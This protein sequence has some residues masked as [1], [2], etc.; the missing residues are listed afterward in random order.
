VC[1]PWEAGLAVLRSTTPLA[2]ARTLHDGGLTVIDPRRPAVRTREVAGQRAV[3]LTKPVSERVL[4][5]TGPLPQH[6]TPADTSAPGV[7][8]AQPPVP[9]PAPETLAPPSDA[10]ASSPGPR[11]SRTPTTSS[12]AGSPRADTA[13]AS[14]DTKPDAVPADARGN[15]PVALYA[16]LREAVADGVIEARYTGDM[17]TAERIL[18]P[19]AAVDAMAAKTGLRP[20]IYRRRITLHA[21]VLAEGADLVLCPRLEGSAA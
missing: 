18:I 13:E 14:V 9:G 7:T 21:A 5:L 15:T 16:A 4:V 11:A 12:L 17:E 6:P 8:S 20:M 1:W 3:M 19:R 2:A 10:G